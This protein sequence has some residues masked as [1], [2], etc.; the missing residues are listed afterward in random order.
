VMPKLGGNDLA[1]EL[2]RLR[3]ATKVL[4]LSGYTAGAAISQGLLSG[5]VELVQKPFTP[6]VLATKVREILDQEA[7]IERSN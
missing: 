5:D 7:E 1:R 2:T 6:R 3:P 4:F